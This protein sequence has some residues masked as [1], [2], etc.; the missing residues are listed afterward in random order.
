MT[1][2]SCLVSKV[3]SER[4]ASTDIW[5]KKKRAPAPQLVW[6]CWFLQVHGRDLTFPSSAPSLGENF[7]PHPHFWKNEHMIRR[8]SWKIEVACSMTRT[9]M[10]RPVSKTWPKTF[11]HTCVFQNNGPGAEACRDMQDF[12][13]PWPWPHFPVLC[14]RSVRNEMLSLTFVKKSA[15]APRLVRPCWFSPAHG[16]DLT[17]PSSAA[18]LGENFCSH[19]HFWKNQ[20]L[21][22]SSSWRIEFLHAMAKTSLVRQLSKTW[23]KIFVPASV[24]Q[25]NGPSAEACQTCEL[26]LTCGH[27]LTLPSCAMTSLCRHKPCQIMCSVELNWYFLNKMEI[28]VL[29]CRC[30]CLQ[31]STN[32]SVAEIL[33]WNFGSFFLKGTF[34]Y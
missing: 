13:S 5:G 24:L 21:V 1:S 18:S 16:R 27:D 9:S 26:F 12:A 3:C 30:L 2:L 19:S 11:I 7:I 31:S 15:P 6:T 4:L 28:H 25:N 20:H 14:P 22:R 29:L 10:S 23:P 32:R 8:S 33:S 34:Y 17:F